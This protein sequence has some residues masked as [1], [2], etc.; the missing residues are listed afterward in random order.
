MLNTSIRSWCRR[1]VKQR[2]LSNIGVCVGRTSNWSGTVVARAWASPETCH[3]GSKYLKNVMSHQ[4]GAR[5]HIPA[6]L[7]ASNSREDTDGVLR[8][9]RSSWRGRGTPSSVFFLSCQQIPRWR[10]LLACGDG[11]QRVDQLQR[12]LLVRRRLQDYARFLNH[13]LHRQLESPPPFG[14][15]YNVPVNVMFG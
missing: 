13:L 1:Q 5:Q 2:S 11:P 14:Q 10:N 12:R 9:S 7:F 4:H 3:T 6:E 8:P 15:Q